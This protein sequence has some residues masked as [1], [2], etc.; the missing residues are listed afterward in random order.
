MQINAE[1]IKQR[2]FTDPT[3]RTRIIRDYG[4]DSRPKNAHDFVAAVLGQLEQEPAPRPLEQS[5]SNADVFRAA[6]RALGSNSRSWATFLKHERRLFGLLHGYDPVHTHRAVERGELSLEQ[7]KSCLPGQSSSA[8][9]SAI[10]R[11]ARLLVEVDHYYGFIQDLG[12]SF[13][14]SSEE[15]YGESLNDA[16]LLLCLALATSVTRRPSGR[17]HATWERRANTCGLISGKHQVWD[18]R[19]LASSCVTYDG[20]VSSQIATF[21]G[22][23]IAGFPVGMQASR[24]RC[25]A[26][27]RSS[28]ATQEI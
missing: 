19:S 12:A 21:N 11:W 2:L 4:I 18:T 13:G 5:V 8:D 23:S 7:I 16:D 15:R 28:G 27:D 20:M 25:N 22:C 1:A 17:A 3:V 26:Y 9:A 14:R 10:L 6:V 24:A